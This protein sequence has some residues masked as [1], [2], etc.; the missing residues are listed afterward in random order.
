MRNV[1]V[2]YANNKDFLRQRKQVFFDFDAQK[3][4]K[5]NLKTMQFFRTFFGNKVK[6]I[7]NR[8]AEIQLAIPV[9][10]DAE[11]KANHN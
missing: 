5:E 9:I 3:L 1:E 4:K 11:I 8:A 7:S 2:T 6:E 10:C